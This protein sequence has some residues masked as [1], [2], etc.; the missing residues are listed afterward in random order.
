M[1]SLLPDAIIIVVV[2][3]VVTAAATGPPQPS[4]TLR[5][6]RPLPTPIAIG[7]DEVGDE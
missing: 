7:V 3:A 2:V 6:L 1:S 4:M 5:R